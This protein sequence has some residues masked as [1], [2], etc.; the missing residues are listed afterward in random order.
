MKTSK[1]KPP[2]YGKPRPA[3]Q[4][5]PGTPYGKAFMPKPYGEATTAKPF[6]QQ[7]SKR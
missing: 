7:K 4:P 5:N 1:R 6:G 3:S 2:E